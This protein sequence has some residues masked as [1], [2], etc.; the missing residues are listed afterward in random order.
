MADQESLTLTVTEAAAL[1]RISRNSAYSLVAQGKIPAVRLGKR[2][3]VP[4][5]A[6]DA[7]LRSSYE[8]PA[9]SKSTVTA[10]VCT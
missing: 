9:A 3:L 2:I 1:L 5:Q 10:T 7:L 6:L 8:T 4:R